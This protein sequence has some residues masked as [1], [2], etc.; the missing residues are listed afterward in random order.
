MKKVLFIHG[1]EKIKEDI[2]GNYY[3]DGCYNNKVW[4][5]YFAISKD[6]TTIFRKENKIYETRTAIKKFQKLDKQIKFVEIKDKKESIKNFLSLKIRKYNKEIIK[7]QVFKSDIVIARVPSDDSYTAIKYAKK[8]NKICLIEVVGCPFDTL[9]NHSIY[10]KVLSF[11]AYFKLKKYVKKAKYVQYVTEEFLQKRYPTNNF[12]IGCSDVDIKELDK[13]V[14]EKRLHKINSY[15]LSKKIVIGTIGTLNVKYKGQSDVMKAIKVLVK[16]G[17]NIEYRLVGAGDD[18]KLK[19]F[20]KKIKVYDYCNF[21]GSIEHEKIFDFID[22]LDIYIHPSH[23]EGLC[24]ALIEVIS[25]ACPTIASNAGGNLE[26]VESEYIYKKKNIDQ[27]I[28]KFEKIIN[29]KSNMK[30]QSIKNFDRS[31]QYTN[32]FLEKKRNKIYSKLNPNIKSKIKVLHIFNKMDKGGAE[33][34]TMN[35]LRNINR[36][37]IEFEFLCTNSEVGAY[38]EEIYNL[39]AK[40]GHILTPSIK[41]PIKSYRQLVQYLKIR[42]PFDVIHIP[43]MFYSGIVC[44]AAYNSGIPKIIVHSHSA[45]DRQTRNPLRFLYRYVMRFM[46]NKYSTHKLS[47]GIEAAKFLYGDI[48]D[49]EVINNGIKLSNYNNVSDNDIKKLKKELNI[50]NEFIIGN[51]ARFVPLK[52]QKF[53]IEIAEQLKKEKFDF[54]IILVGEGEEKEEIINEVIK[55]DLDKYF[56][57]PGLR[58][59]IPV[60][61]NLFDVLVMP[62]LYEGFPLTVVEALASATPCILSSNISKE[63][64]LIDNMVEF[65]ELNSEIS[66]WV[67]KIKKASKGNKLEI[68]KILREKG[69]DINNTVKKLE[70]IYVRR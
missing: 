43:T 4:E 67:E 65:L 9:W 59:D 35:V 15:D 18:H 5:R 55:R 28:Q 11:H 6:I 24:R 25:R 53:F 27:L 51:V 47:C 42:G 20:A 69:F 70:M 22:N 44:K 3:T 48:N 10:G 64:K 57:F 7:Q 29:S 31:K 61:M 23:T 37:K 21:I 17:Y 32:Y 66:L 58:S 40:I 2:E 13:K 46:I 12:Q 38:D 49:V 26:L 50:K 36:N 68:V 60:F 14:L 45:K 34:F 16:K 19:E 39:G 56:I 33:T 52:N 54:K 63:T 41:N 30:E 62:S 8:Y 1:D